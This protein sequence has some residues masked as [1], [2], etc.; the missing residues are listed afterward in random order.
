MAWKREINIFSFITRAKKCKGKIAPPEI[1]TENK[2]FSLP[3]VY[4]LTQNT[5]ERNIF[6]RSVQEQDKFIEDLTVSS[7]SIKQTTHRSGRYSVEAIAPLQYSG[8]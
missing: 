4:S 3:V 1:F 8:R 5:V 7:S 2:L 6:V